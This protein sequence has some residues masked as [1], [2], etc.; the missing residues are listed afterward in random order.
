[1]SAIFYILGVTLVAQVGGGNRYDSP[2]S[3]EPLES[4]GDLLNEPPKSAPATDSTTAPPAGNSTY[5]TATNNPVGSSTSPPERHLPN[6]QT[7]ESS[8]SPYRPTTPFTSSTASSTAVPPTTHRSTS[9]PT[10]LIEAILTKPADSQL[11]GNPV[12]LR[13]I[14]QGASSRA[15]QSARVE[16]YW[17]LCSAVADYYLGLT[18]QKELAALQQQ[19]PAMS[20]AL[21]QAD[22]ELKS[23]V[24]TA[25]R[26]AR[27]AQMRLAGLM[28]RSTASELPLPEDVPHCGDYLTR[29]EEKF[30][31]GA[32][33][34][35]RE[36][37]ELL[38]LRLDELEAE[39]AAVA[40]SQ[41]WVDAVAGQRTVNSDGTGVIHALELLALH[42]RAFVQLV[43]DYNRKITRYTE[44]A[45][46]GRL[47]T[48]RLVAM[49]IRTDDTP[50]V[51]QRQSESRGTIPR[52]ET[53][54]TFAPATSAS[55]D[56][57]MVLP[58]EQ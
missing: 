45:T 4:L 55:P 13:Q 33:L 10:E 26:A 7:S 54:R 3:N 15:E 36:L 5:R 47:S 56:D 2:P 48:D 30:A 41:K 24:A 38:P 9:A 20:A 6:A 28:G 1:M 39:A 58:I 29:Y 11:E 27:V 46:P 57:G 35:A 31:N 49:L 40:R 43:R 42:R 37:H 51:A 14:V 32:V 34:E 52:S 16:A 25:Q 44:L 12:R 19:M 50:A 22:E 17:D 18:E 53:P 21:R 23:R 8:T